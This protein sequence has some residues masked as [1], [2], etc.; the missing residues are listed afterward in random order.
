VG[1]VVI[2]KDSCLTMAKVC[3]KLIE[4]GIF[5]GKTWSRLEKKIKI[6]IKIKILKKIFFVFFF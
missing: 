1:D 2:G 6:K 3:M 4:K 5:H